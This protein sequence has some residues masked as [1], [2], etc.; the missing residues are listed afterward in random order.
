MLSPSA[1]FLRAHELSA[2]QTT[3][4]R[5]A[6]PLRRCAAFFSSGSSGRSRRLFPP[7]GARFQNGRAHS[8]RIGYNDRCAAR[9]HG[10]Y[11]RVATA[12]Q[13]APPLRRSDAVAIAAEFN[14]PIYSL[15]AKPDIK[16]FA[17]LKGKLLGMAD[18][19]GTITYPRAG[20]SRCTD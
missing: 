10:G 7:R 12:F 2:A 19:A 3:V 11:H 8:G 17:D 16:S 1:R 5:Y 4:A 6:Q 13:F 9:R 15:I 20:C 18:E 14:N